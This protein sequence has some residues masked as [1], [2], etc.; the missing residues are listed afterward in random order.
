MKLERAERCG[1]KLLEW[2]SPHAE[3]IEVA[4]SLRRRRPEV[5]RIDLVVIPKRREERDLLGNVASI[6]N[7]T[8]EEIDRRIT[9][10]NW[11]VERAGA[12]LV[13]WW[14]KDVRVDLH[15][16]EP[17]V[18]G[19]LLM[20]HT[21][22]MD[23]GVWLSKYALSLGGKWFPGDGLYMHRRKYSDSEQSIYDALGLRFVAPED[24]EISR[25]PFA[26]LIRVDNRG[27]T[28]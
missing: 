26:G 12:R 9:V 20:T 11:R 8:W 22:S 2:L 16:S 15:W 3:R 14:A 25:L 6:R 17:Q 18:W 1:I 23:H 28:R 13:T 19:A 21:G 7:A 24:R 5:D 4:G 27:L 10:E